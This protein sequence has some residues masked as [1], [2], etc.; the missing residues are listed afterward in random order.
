MSWSQFCV[1]PASGEASVH[2]ADSPPVSG[3][4]AQWQTSLGAGLETGAF[5]AGATTQKV[6]RRRA[7]SLRRKAP[8]TIAK[9]VIMAHLRLAG[10]MVSDAAALGGSDIP[11]A[12]GA[13]SVLLMWRRH[14]PGLRQDRAA[15]GN[16]A[17][18]SLHQRC[19]MR[20]ETNPSHK[21][22]MGLDR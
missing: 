22:E 17:H 6:A 3:S 5:A 2:L 21:G 11:H 1:A 19:G 20:R 12:V 13:A 9:F 16:T 14:A 4:M 18:W 10:R 15:R 8:S 7:T